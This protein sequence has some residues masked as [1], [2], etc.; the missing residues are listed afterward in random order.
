MLS[1]NRKDRRAINS[2]YKN[3]DLTFREKSHVFGLI[4]ILKGDP[5]Y[6]YRAVKTQS[7]HPR[8]KKASPRIGR[9]VRKKEAILRK[10]GAGRKTLQRLNNRL[11][12]NNMMNQEGQIDRRITAKTIAFSRNS[13]RLSPNNLETLFII[14]NNSKLHSIYIPLDFNFKYLN[15]FSQFWDWEDSPDGLVLK[16]YPPQFANRLNF[17]LF[18][19][20]PH[21][22]RPKKEDLISKE[23][24]AEIKSKY[25]NLM[26][27]ENL[28]P[29][30]KYFNPTAQLKGGYVPEDDQRLSEMDRQKRIR[31][32]T[33]QLQ[34]KYFNPTA[35]LKGG[36]VPEDDQ[37]LSEMDRQKRIRYFTQQLQKKYFNPTAQLKGGYV[38]EDDQRLS[39]MDRQKRIR[40]FTQQLQKK[41]GKP[42]ES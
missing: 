13:E 29:Q 31:Y 21:L 37:R 39:E 33:Q 25:P 16:K 42:K 7:S 19:Q 14:K 35:Q 26:K 24:I 4:S 27:K 17:L 36:Y 32:F 23:K 34:K 3:T 6:E 22:K 28:P 20:S 41:Y 10:I 38:P 9:C 15:K 11:K 1:M 2:I 18:Q 40:Y 30:K 5:L 8:F 12:E